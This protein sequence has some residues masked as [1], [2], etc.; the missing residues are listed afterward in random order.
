MAPARNNS[1]RPLSSSAL[2]ARMTPRAVMMPA[3]I[4]TNPP[5]RHIVNP[6][7]RSRS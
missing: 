3:H 5:T 4:A 2:L 6:P 1:A 7:T